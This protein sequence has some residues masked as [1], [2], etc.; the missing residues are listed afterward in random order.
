MVQ[1]VHIL[2]DYPSDFYGLELRVVILGFIRPE[3]NYAGL[4]ER[5]VAAGRA[6]A[7]ICMRVHQYACL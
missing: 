2:H 4:G 6:V 7:R 3:Y 1:E 5:N